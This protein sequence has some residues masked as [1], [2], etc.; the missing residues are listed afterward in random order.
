MEASVS[1]AGIRL[2]EDCSPEASAERCI[3]FSGVHFKRRK[4]PSWQ[5][6]DYLASSLFV[7]FMAI[8]PHLANS[9]MFSCGKLVLFAGVY[10][11]SDTKPPPIPQTI[12]AGWMRLYRE[13]GSP[14]CGGSDMLNKAKWNDQIWTE[15]NI[16]TSVRVP[17]LK[18]LR[19]MAEFYVWHK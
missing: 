14:L 13:S 4:S 8:I 3:K 16:I 10:C 1:I 17:W 12:A 11:T 5:W 18:L 6:T 15:I 2:R 19:I 7:L 9:A